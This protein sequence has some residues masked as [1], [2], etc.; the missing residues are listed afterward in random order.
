[1]GLRGRGWCRSTTAITH[2]H[3]NR[4]DFHCLV[5]LDEDFLNNPGDGGG[6]LGVDLVRRDFD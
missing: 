4:S 5:F 3:K 6:N 2:T 1:L